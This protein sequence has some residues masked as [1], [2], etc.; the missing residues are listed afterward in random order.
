[1]PVV[2]RIAGLRPD[3][4]AWRQ[5]LHAHPELGYQEHRTSTFVAERLREF[6][7]DEVVTGLGKTGVVGVIRG[8]GAESDRNM[9]VLGL[10][11]DMDALPIEEAT[12]LPYTSKTRGVMH[13]C[14]HDGHTAML[15]GAARYLSETRN[16]TG[17]AVI[18]FQ[19]AEES[20]AGAKAMIEDGLMER[21]GIGQV[22][23]M[24]NQPGLPVGTFALREG[25]TLAAAD[26]VSISI[27]G[28]GGHS[29]NPHE[30]I[31]PVFVGA[32]LITAL[33]Q[34][35]ASNVDPREPATLS[36]SVF[37]SG[38]SGSIIP[39]KADLNGR[40][41]TTTPKMRQF[42]RQRV[43]EV[44]NGVAGLTGAKID[45]SIRDGYPVTFNHAAESR[46][47]INVAKEVA[48]EGNVVEAPLHM[49]SEDFSYML[50]ARPGAFIFC[51]NG[52][53]A[54]L[55][56]PGYD[57]NDEAILHGTSFWIRLVET[58]LRGDV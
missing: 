50:Q 18:I 24:H 58:A 12:N 29:A 38:N 23:G 16:F 44:V 34:I 57:F 1:M 9:K 33:E 7:C 45:L 8:R 22:F 11:A 52:D 26:P 42:I 14:G 37:N 19:P 2:N 17:S 56:N 4:Q 36:I 10:R 55:H 51:G 49:G 6:G 47:A 21:F 31:N 3:I 28:R 40:I 25:P 20:G 30:C 13:A 48:G 32:Q 43:G 53:S 27:Q 41:R 35:V 15:L 39:E 46:F 54:G 5:D